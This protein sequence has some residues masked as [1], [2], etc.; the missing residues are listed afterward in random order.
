MPYITPCSDPPFALGEFIF[1]LTDLNSDPGPPV[2][3]GKHHGAD[4]PGWGR[5]AGGAGRQQSRS[6][7]NF[8][9]QGPGSGHGSARGV[10]RSPAA[11]PTLLPG[12]GAEGRKAADE[13][14][15]PVASPHPPETSGR[16]PPGAEGRRQG[17]T[18]RGAGATY[19]WC[20]RDLLLLLLLLLLPPP[21]TPLARREAREA[22]ARTGAGAAAAR[23]LRAARLWVRVAHPGKAAW[24]TPRPPARRH[25]ATAGEGRAATEGGEG[26]GP[27]A[28]PPA[29]KEGA[30]G[31]VPARSGGSRPS[32]RLRA[33]FVRGAGVG[34]LARPA[35]G[36]HG[37]E[38]VRGAGPTVRSGCERARRGNP[39]Q[40]PTHS[41]PGAAGAWGRSSVFPPPH[42]CPGPPGR[43]GWVFTYGAA[44]GIFLR[45][46]PS[47][48]GWICGRQ[49]ASA[50][51]CG[52]GCWLVKES[53]AWD[54]V[55]QWGNGRRE[56]RARV[57]SRWAGRQPLLRSSCKR[58]RP[59]RGSL[60]AAP[61]RGV[62]AQAGCTGRWGGLKMGSMAF[63]FMFNNMSSRSILQEGE[64]KLDGKV[65]FRWAVWGK[66]S[67]E[68]TARWSPVAVHFAEPTL[69]VL[70]PKLKGFC[71]R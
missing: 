46:W 33:S 47:L 18:Q 50:A 63:K 10:R 48:N 28:A 66:E 30:E 32:P 15:A 40:T 44:G 5:A 49:A 71:T 24:E 1:P 4:Q 29:G 58:P 13:E 59:R 43:R 34:P 53:G 14:V 7:G 27:A 22:C 62:R 16:R 39:R 8:A 61:R 60:P 42:T 67:V 6:R 20:R 31:R 56:G 65:F 52:R 38:G 11:A 2:P 21:P 69:Q 9:P 41:P 64:I 51:A 70:P 55:R 17:A 57:R 54:R 25:P 37:G 45:C 19:P 35:G 26:A 23:S 68:E 3:C 12:W 36:W